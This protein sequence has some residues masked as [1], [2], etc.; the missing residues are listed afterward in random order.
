VDRKNIEESPTPSRR[1]QETS[2]RTKKGLQVV[3][4]LMGGGEG[5]EVIKSYLSL[6]SYQHPKDHLNKK[7][8]QIFSNKVWG[9]ERKQHPHFRGKKKTPRKKARFSFFWEKYENAVRGLISKQ[10][11]QKSRKRL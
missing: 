3:C 6:F 8:H 7:G 2:R 11:P 4:N 5:G 1:Q 10:Q 9:G